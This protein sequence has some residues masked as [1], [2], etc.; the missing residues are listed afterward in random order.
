VALFFYLQNLLTK[1][2][3]KRVKWVRDK[4]CKCLDR[5]INFFYDQ[6]VSLKEGINSKKGGKR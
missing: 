6:I 2:K 4:L 1:V 5:D 3:D